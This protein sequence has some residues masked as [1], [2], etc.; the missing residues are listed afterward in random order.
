LLIP[1]IQGGQQISFK[2][3]LWGFL[4]LREIPVSLVLKLL[5][6]FRCVS[7]GGRGVGGES[8]LKVWGGWG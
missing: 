6:G 1:Q 7:P 5:V 3:T 2:G 4:T 8:R